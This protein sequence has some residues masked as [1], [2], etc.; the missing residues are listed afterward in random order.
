MQRLATAAVALLALVALAGAAGTFG[1]V[2]GPVVSD[3]GTPTGP[4]TPT[5]LP[6]P[7]GAPG[8]AADS[9][10][11]RAATPTTAAAGDSGGVSPFVVP[12]VGGSLFAA[13]LLVV[14]LTGHD[15]RA[16][17]VPD[18]GAA[19]EDPTPTVS[20][21]YDSPE[22]NAV[23]RAWRRL[24]DRS[25]ADETATPGD[26][27]ARALDRRIPREPVATITERF[28]A[29][30]YGRES[31]GDDREE[32][33]VE[34]ADA[35]DSGDEVAGRAAESDTADDGPPDHDPVDSR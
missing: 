9:E 26:V 25:D 34:A 31:S 21:A 35:I 13:G 14:F 7:T 6:P 15:E 19:G 3:N 8:G 4:A 20:P 1:A 24:R 11:R 17:A 2:E 18:D 10:V 33:A 32:P 22:E 16:P 5:E 27:A 29:V 12:A 23:T 28:R 30:R